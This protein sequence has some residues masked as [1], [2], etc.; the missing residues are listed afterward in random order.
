M[1]EKPYIVSEE[2]LNND[3]SKWIGLKLLRW[4]DEDG[5]DRVSGNPSSRPMSNAEI[6]LGNR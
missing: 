2:S 4:K 6:D 3:D 5:K 1:A